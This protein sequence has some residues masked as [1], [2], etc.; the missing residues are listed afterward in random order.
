MRRSTFIFSIG[1]IFCIRFYFNEYTNPLY[2]VAKT[3]K[4]LGAAGVSEFR[5]FWILEMEY[6]TRTVVM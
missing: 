3:N 6:G 1:Y 5:S 4:V 2:L